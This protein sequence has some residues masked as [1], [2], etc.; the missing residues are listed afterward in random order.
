MS[1]KLAFI[2]KLKNLQKL[3]NLEP[4]AMRRPDKAFGFNFSKFFNFFKFDECELCGHSYKY[5]Y[6]SGLHA[7]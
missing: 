4:I 7:L 6:V 1:A 2:G 5:L 3:K